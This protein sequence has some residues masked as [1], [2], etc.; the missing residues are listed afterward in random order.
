MSVLLSF[1]FLLFLTSTVTV[2]HVAE[3]CLFQLLSPSAI[4]RDEVR[5]LLNVLVLILHRAIV[6]WERANELL[7]CQGPYTLLL[8]AVSC[9]NFLAS[10][11]Y[12]ASGVTMRNV[13]QS[14]QWE[15]GLNDSSPLLN[16][17]LP[18]EAACWIVWEGEV[19][20]FIEEFLEI[21]LATV[22]RFASAPDNGHANFLIE[23]LC[24]PLCQCLLDTS[25]D[26][27]ILRAACLLLFAF[28]LCRPHSFS[29]V[30][31]DNGWLI[32]LGNKHGCCNHFIITLLA[33]WVLTVN[34]VGGKI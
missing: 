31:V 16:E 32:R 26:I 7:H 9:Q 5:E 10:D 6:Q 24:L 21:F 13:G 27:C 30:D 25:R 19:N 33:A 18:H 28:F 3:E 4:S 2:F 1:L 22:V 23:E 29:L 34:K 11:L 14:T 20:G 17:L 8:Q 12:A 15:F